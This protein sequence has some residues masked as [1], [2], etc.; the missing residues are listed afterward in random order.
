MTWKRILYID[1]KTGVIDMRMSPTDPNTLIIASW[2][3][4]RD[5]YV[6][7]FE[8]PPVPDQYGPVVTHAPGSALFK[9]TDGG[10]NFKKITSGVPTVKLARTCL[11]D[12]VGDRLYVILPGTKAEGPKLLV[13]Q[14]R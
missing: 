12:P 9:T 11:F 8:N 3:H 5:E 7:Y 14:P 10:E 6:G 1:D 2:E 4:K 13:Y